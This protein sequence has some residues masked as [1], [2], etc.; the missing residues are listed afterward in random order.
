MYVEMWILLGIKMWYIDSRNCGTSGATIFGANVIKNILDH[1]LLN[2][3][4]LDAS[5]LVH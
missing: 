2:V 1:I 3:E 4:S 5:H